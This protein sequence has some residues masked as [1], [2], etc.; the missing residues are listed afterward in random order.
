MFDITLGESYGLR[1]LSPRLL[2][3]AALH[4]DQVL[5]K[6]FHTTVIARWREPRRMYDVS[7]QGAAATPELPF[8]DRGTWQQSV[9]LGP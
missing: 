2:G 4:T 3:R 9:A 1:S 6:R 5:T 8:F 7:A